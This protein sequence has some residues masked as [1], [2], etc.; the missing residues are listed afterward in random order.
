MGRS[1]SKSSSFKVSVSIALHLILFSTFVYLLEFDKV[2]VTFLKNSTDIFMFWND[3][4]FLHGMLK[5]PGSP[6]ADTFAINPL[7]YRGTNDLQSGYGMFKIVDYDN[8]KPTEDD[9]NP[10]HV[11]KAF[12]TT[13]VFY[14]PL[15]YLSPARPGM[16]RCLQTLP[17]RYWISFDYYHPVNTSYRFRIHGTPVQFRESEVLHEF[18]FSACNSNHESDVTVP[19]GFYFQRIMFSFVTAA[20]LAAVIRLIYLFAG[21]LLGLVFRQKRKPVEESADDMVASE[22][23]TEPPVSRK[24]TGLRKLGFGLQLLLIFVA[25]YA[26]IFYY[27]Y[28]HLNHIPRVVDE[29]G[30]LF[31][32]KIFAS[33]CLSVPAPDYVD[34]LDYPGIALFRDP[35]KVYHRPGFPGLPV[36]LAIGTLF[37]A[38]WVIPPLV[39]SLGFIFIF[40]IGKELFSY[41][42]AWGAII[43]AWSSPWITV[44]GAS[45]M[46]HG[47]ALCWGS[48]FMYYLIRFLRYGY[49]SSAILCAIAFGAEVWTRPFTA[50]CLML[51]FIIPTISRYVFRPR[52]WKKI[53]VMILIVALFAAGLYMYIKAQG[54][55]CGLNPNIESSKSLHKWNSLVITAYNYFIN[56]TELNLS[57]FGWP[58]LFSLVFFMMSLIFIQKDD[59]Q[60]ALLLTF[61]STSVLYSLKG[62][63]GWCYEPRYWYGAV[64]ALTIFT[65]AGVQ[66]LAKILVGHLRWWMRWL[67]IT[68]CIIP[69]ALIGNSFLAPKYINKP[70]VK[71]LTKSRISGWYWRQ[72]HRFDNYCNI[73]T[74]LRDW[75]EE[76]KPK[77]ALVI[78]GG[79]PSIWTMTP[80][81]PLI[82]LNFAGDVVFVKDMQTREANQKI[83]DEFPDREVYWSNN[84]KVVPY[85]E[86]VPSKKSPAKRSSIAGKK[87]GKEKPHKKVGK[88]GKKEKK[89]S[90]SKKKKGKKPAGAEKHKNVGKSAGKKQNSAG[91]AGK[92]Q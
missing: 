35:H 89:K 11:K 43:L 4:L 24:R 32:A 71:T 81:I 42:V 77:N 90:A 36:L 54:V 41:W 64:P 38:P 75:V 13:N 65:A 30:Y 27:T 73:K 25:G 15:G 14:N 68:A 84:G 34:F 74:D 82:N 44:L 60:N 31:Q 80:I 79:G 46:T 55:V 8:P 48:M 61:F 17:E 16:I 9:L 88:Q 3:H 7:F 37:H 1:N 87:E 49:W 92:K 10:E 12:S 20:T 22:P 29:A 63:F 19:Y 21:F 33:G 91:K 69:L 6:S 70:W 78:V 76:E 26:L 85:S 53:I 23:V 67:G 52:E 51:P 50:F 47:T 2:R 62:H 40:L 18:R 39:T 83:I 45:F 86:Y 5:R 57:L 59:L 72:F 58:V 28:F 56:L 66:Y